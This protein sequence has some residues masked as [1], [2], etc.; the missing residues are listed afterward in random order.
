MLTSKEGS[1]TNRLS[2]VHTKQTNYG[3]IHW[4]KV[5]DLKLACKRGNEMAKVLPWILSKY[6]H[7]KSKAGTKWEYMRRQFIRLTKNLPTG[8]LKSSFC[9]W[10]NFRR[11]HAMFIMEIVLKP[12]YSANSVCEALFKMVISLSIWWIDLEWKGELEFLIIMSEIRLLLSFK[13]QPWIFVW[14]KCMCTHLYLCVPTCVYL[15]V[16][17]WVHFS[18]VTISLHLVWWCEHLWSHCRTPLVLASKHCCQW[19]LNVFTPCLLSQTRTYICL[20]IL[21]PLCM[22]C[23]DLKVDDT[24]L[25]LVLFNLYLDP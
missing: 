14:I 1:L 12:I 20:N 24:P 10:P 5:L 19:R 11:G 9:D 16:C 18:I 6:I 21:I 4:N 7:N 2:A 23:L 3:L 13:W 8:Q 22:L 25:C 17:V 15:C